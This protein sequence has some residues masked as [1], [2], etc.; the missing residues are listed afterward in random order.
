MSDALTQA[1]IDKAIKDALATAKTEWD[2]ETEGLKNKN[3]ELIGKLRDAQ[4][5]KPEEWWLVPE[6]AAA[7]D[8]LGDLGDGR[9]GVAGLRGG[10]RLAQGGLQT[11]DL[12]A[13]GKQ[14]KTLTKERDDATKALEAEQTTARTAAR[15]AA[16]NGAIADGQVLPALA[17]ALRALFGTQAKVDLADGAYSVLIGDKPAGEAIK[18]FLDTDDGKHYRAA[19]VNGGGGA[20]GGGGQ[21]GAKT[22][23]RSQFDGMSHVDRS[24]FAKDG[25]KV[26]DEAA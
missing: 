20:P 14:V 21:V 18:A 4:G 11:A 25:G 8:D 1:D 22:V 2:A 23:T 6:L 19:P 24:A 16:I 9:P 17:P 3:R 13:L 5:V 10:E 15:D 7:V 26:V 12:A